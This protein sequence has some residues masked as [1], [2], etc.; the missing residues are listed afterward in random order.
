MR[1]S[2]A[3]EAIKARFCLGFPSNVQSICFLSSLLEDWFPGGVRIETLHLYKLIEG[4]RPKILL[5]DNAVVADDE[6]LHAGHA[7]FSRGSYQ[8][9]ARR[10]LPPFTTKSIFADWLQRVLDLSKS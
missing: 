2:S 6:G 7:V 9:E 10:S 4:G 3:H 8:G 5:E 1:Q